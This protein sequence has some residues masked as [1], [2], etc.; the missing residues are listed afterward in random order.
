MVS[1]MAF[2]VVDM[3]QHLAAVLA[4]PGMEFL[5]LCLRA[6]IDYHLAC[7]DWRESVLWLGVLRLF[8]D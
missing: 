6:R 5:C 7:L 2:Y 8:E 4:R 1:L 3:R